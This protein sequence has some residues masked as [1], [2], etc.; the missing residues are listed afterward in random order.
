[1]YTYDI[2]SFSDLHKEAR[3]FRPSET[4]YQWLSEASPKELQ[5]EWDMLVNSAD[6]RYQEEVLRLEDGATRLKASIQEMLS[7]GAQSIKDCIRWLHDAYETN[8]D[9][10]YLDYKLGVKYGTIQNLAKN[11]ELTM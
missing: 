6:L 4:Y 3:G 11:Q 7:I 8:G 2:D 5:E 9:N 10:E 1:M